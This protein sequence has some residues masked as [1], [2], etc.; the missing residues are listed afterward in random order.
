[1]RSR[2]WKRAEPPVPPGDDVC[3]TPPPV[4]EEPPHDRFCDLVL[5]GGVASGVVYPWAIVE[6]ARAYR[7]RSIGGSS[8]GAMAAALA[9]AAEYGRRTGAAHPFEPL[10]RT[11]AALGEELPEGRTRL[12]SLFQPHARGKRLLELWRRLGR[13]E[14]PERPPSWRERLGHLL[15][16]VKEPAECAE[17]QSQDS[18]PPRW[19]Q[20]DRPLPK[21]RVLAQLLAVY[22]EPCGAGAS[23][24][25]ALGLG[26]AGLVPSPLCSVWQAVALGLLTLLLAVAGLLV[27]LGVALWTDIREGVVE[28]DFGLC[29][30]GTLEG[31]GPDDR[32]R[33]GLSEWLHNGIQASAGLQKS[34]APLTFRDLWS[35]P[36]FPGAPR[37]NCSTDDP[38]RLR[39]IDLQM[40]TTNVTHGRP[41][42][43]PLT[44]RSTRLFFLPKELEGYF[45]EAV[46]QALAKAPPYEPKLPS[47][48][49]VSNRTRG[50]HELPDIDLPIVVAARLSLS[51]PFLFSAVPLYAIDREDPDP[52]HRELR[53]CRFSDGGVSSN[54]PIHLFDATIP[55]WPTF[56]LWLTRRTPYRYQ[57]KRRERHQV[58]GDDGEED[59]WLP[60]RGEQGRGDNWN[61]F[62]PDVEPFAQPKPGRKAGHVCGTADKLLGFVSAIANSA[63]DWRDRTALRMPHV[64]QRVMRLLLRPG[65][66]GLNIGMPRQQILSMAHRYGT[67][68]GRDFVDRFIDCGGQPSAA[69]RAQRWIRM[70]LLLQTLRERLGRL[71]V[72]LAWASRTQ[73]MRVAIM[74]AGT[75]GTRPLEADQVQTLLHLLDELERAG[76]ALTTHD[77][78]LEPSMPMPELRMRP[79]L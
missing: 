57:R 2:L 18:L 48:P 28:N 25:A 51:F 31:N 40:V 50:Y 67:R 69:W 45:P 15:R 46:M 71:S 59:Y 10:R 78:G 16:H 43:L 41:Y 52:L 29:K 42:R 30:G 65:E 73:P 32:P 58:P 19:T 56:G 14:A 77:P 23:I 60:E 39:A 8:V 44:D 76:Q 38:P 63:V 13:G 24:G 36:S 53:R 70:T 7:F 22:A 3:P 37:R 66:G 75:T 62:E 26:F 21:H 68:A 64:R 20:R 11:P 9:A 4:D 74:E 49:P 6:L 5:T 55:A 34:D 54:F 27:A 61:R 1:M 47:D 12:Y 35:A 33:P 79:P 17:Q 72:N